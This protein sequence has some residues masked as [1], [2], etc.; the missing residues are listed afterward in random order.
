MLSG[1]TRSVVFLIKILVWETVHHNVFVAKIGS[2]SR[3]RGSSGGKQ[4]PV[5]RLEWLPR[6]FKFR[7]GTLRYRGETGVRTLVF[8]NRS[9][10][11]GRLSSEIDKCGPKWTGRYGDDQTAHLNVF[12]LDKESTHVRAV[13]L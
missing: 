12:K 5:A 4:R 2:E 8:L 10:Q 3:S 13:V 7:W 6:N 9:L 1:S 11:A